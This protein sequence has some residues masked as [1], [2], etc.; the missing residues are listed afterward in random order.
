MAGNLGIHHVFVCV[1]GHLVKFECTAGDAAR[2][3]SETLNIINRE[4][5]DETTPLTMLIS[6]AAFQ[7][8]MVRLH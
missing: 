7:A 4:V 6:S 3:L 1:M 5:T 8:G 2:E